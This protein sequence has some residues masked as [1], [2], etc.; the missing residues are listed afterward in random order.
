[1]VALWDGSLGALVALS[2]DRRLHINRPT[3]ADWCIGKRPALC[4]HILTYA[5]SPFL[6][7]GLIAVGECKQ[8]T[9]LPLFRPP[10]GGTRPGRSG[11]FEIASRFDFGVILPL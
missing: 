11:P 9:Q 6:V 2:L 7:L 8:R 5:L 1:V 3:N 4:F 10:L